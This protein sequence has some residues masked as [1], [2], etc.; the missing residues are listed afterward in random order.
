MRYPWNNEKFTAF[1][2]KFG[3]YKYMVM[4]FGMC[5]APATFRRAIVRILSL[6]LGIKLVHNTKTHIDEDERM[7]VVAYI[8]TIFIATKGSFEKHHKQVSKDFQLLME[9][10]R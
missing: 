2:T 1:G 6:L 5:H 10:N 7:V 9:E 3:L 8:D 4:P